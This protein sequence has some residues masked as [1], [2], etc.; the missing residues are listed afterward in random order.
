MGQCSLAIVLDPVQL[1]QQSLHRNFKLSRAGI[2]SVSTLHYA[3]CKECSVSGARNLRVVA[4][5]EL[6]SDSAHAGLRATVA[7]CSLG[8]SGERRLGFAFQIRYYVEVLTSIG[9]QL[10]RQLCRK[11][12]FASVGKCVGVSKHARK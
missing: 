7:P 3:R 8:V 1:L 11:Q 10:L 6:F 5:P 4:S 9:R 2:R 12:M